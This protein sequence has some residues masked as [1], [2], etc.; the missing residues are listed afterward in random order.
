[1]GRVAHSCTRRGAPVARPGHLDADPRSIQLAYDLA[2]I[3][4]A[5]IARIEQWASSAY[6]DRGDGATVAVQTR[7]VHVN[8]LEVR[9]MPDGD[10]SRSIVRFKY[11]TDKD[12]WTVHRLF[13]GG[14]WL[15]TKP[16]D[17]PLRAVLAGV[18]LER[19]PPP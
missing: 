2:V 11:L 15:P 3:S 9:Q 1:M 8:V 7:G 6:P 18:D 13:A 14:R 19:L 17:G 10:R 12:L 4:P 5:D 16:D